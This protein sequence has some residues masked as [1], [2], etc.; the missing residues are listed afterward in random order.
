[1]TRNTSEW[2]NEGA[3]CSLSSILEVAPI[4]Q[5]FFLSRKACSGIIRRAEKRG[6]EL[7][8]QLRAALLAVAL[9]EDQK[10]QLETIL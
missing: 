1:L 6:K 5:R 10:E 3:A 9:A 4:P 8:E 7:P 2:R